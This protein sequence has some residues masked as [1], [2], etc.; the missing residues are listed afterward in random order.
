MIEG[1]TSHMPHP[2]ARAIET[3]HRAVA[4]F[5]ERGEP[6]CPTVAP[7]YCTPVQGGTPVRHRTVA[8]WLGIKAIKASSR[9]SLPH[10]L[11][12]S[13]YSG[14]LSRGSGVQSVNEFTF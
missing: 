13:K 10:L 14:A 12:R 3:R 6:V 4:Q 8:A 11:Q 1:A 7:W 2:G 5:D 9:L